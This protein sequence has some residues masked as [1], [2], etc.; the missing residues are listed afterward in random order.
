MATSSLAEAL[1]TP[2]IVRLIDS[3]TEL[4]PG[5]PSSTEN[6]Q[7][8]WKY[9]SENKSWNDC[10]D[11][12]FIKIIA[13]GRKRPRLEVEVQG[14]A[15]QRDF[16]ERKSF[17]GSVNGLVEALAYAKYTANKVRAKEFCGRCLTAK[18]FDGKRDFPVKRL[19]AEPL[20]YCAQCAL[21]LAIGRAPQKKM[22]KW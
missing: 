15:P 22:R 2:E 20:P 8:L 13:Q 3:Y 21:Q 12:V 5:V 16:F 7:P 14:G 19:K 1:E 9:I 17:E 10:E 11:D 4:L 6:V 18:T